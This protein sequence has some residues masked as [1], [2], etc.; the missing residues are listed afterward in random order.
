MKSKSIIILILGILIGAVAAYLITPAV[1]TSGSESQAEAEQLYSC[2]MHPEVISEE[3]GNCPICG[4]KLT[5]IQSTEQDSPKE[6]ITDSSE[7]AKI[8]YWRAPMD[9]TEIYDKPGKSKM[10]MDL[11]PVY[12]GEEAGGAGHITIDGVVQQNMNLRIAPVKRRDMYHVIRAYGKVSYAEDKQFTVSTKI[13]G[14]IEKLYLDTT[15]Q[16]VRR[17]QPL[18][19]IY[20]PELVSTQE[21]Y[22]LAIKN[23]Q[24]LSSSSYESVRKNAE[25]M[26]K[27]SQ[28]RLEYWDIPEEE[29]DQIK[30]TRQVSRTIV[31]RSQVAGVVTH[32]AVTEGD[33]VGPGMDLFHIAD[34][35]EV[36]VEATVYESELPFVN[37]GQKAEL[38]LDHIMGEVR[39]GRVDFIYPYLDQNSKANT[40]RL[41]F[42]NHGQVLK[43]DMYATVRIH[44]ASAQD[45]LAVPSEAVIH[46]GK[47]QIV[48]VSRGDGK[49]D[50]REIK[51]GVE[52][53]DGYVHVVS[54]LLDHEKVVVSGQFLLDS[55]SRTREAIAKMRE[56]RSQRTH[57]TIKKERQDTAEPEQEEHGIESQENVLKTGT[58]QTLGHSHEE[59]KSEKIELDVDK[60]YACPRHPEFITTDPNAKCPEC[61]MKIVAVKELG[62]KVDLDEAQ[63]YTCPMH[64]DFLTTDKDA[65]CPECGMKLEKV[66]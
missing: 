48:F 55:E 26:L 36:W 27:L 8:L 31:L 45:V 10:G 53:E 51:V 21:E 38:Q 41:V 23:Y 34:L 5:P 57:K 62:D 66:K 25:K 61:G 11:V 1:S 6:G 56:A 58:Q 7:K 43:P 44:S 30:E 13:N 47:R 49:F 32:K 40:V 60:L 64:P 65:R 4:M 33:K 54:G 52:S 19:E 15:G 37:V 18:L 2:G 12:A 50:P 24:K 17:G 28:E 9:P 29:I 59:Q 20:S 46:S 39:V 22:L 42:E 3:P 35:D 16:K 63:F 14:W